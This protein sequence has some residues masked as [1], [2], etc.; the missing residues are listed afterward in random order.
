MSGH[1]F[2]RGDT[3]T[4]SCPICLSLRRLGQILTDPS[5]SVSFVNEGLL[6]LQL[7]VIRTQDK[8]ELDLLNQREGEGGAAPPVPPTNRGVSREEEPEGVTGENRPRKERKRRRD[9]SSPQRPKAKE[10]ASS[11]K[12]ISREDRSAS[13]KEEEGKPKKDKAHKKDKKSRSRDRTKRDKKNPKEKSASKEESPEKRRALKAAPLVA[14]KKESSEEEVTEEEEKEE[15]RKSPRL[16]SI[17]PPR[18][19]ANPATLGLETLPPRPSREAETGTPA[20]SGREERR[21]EERDEDRRERGREESS[22]RPRQ[23]RENSYHHPSPHQW[24]SAPRYTPKGAKKREK[25]AEIRRAGGVANWYASKK[26]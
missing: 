16:P 17:T 8:G 22:R 11:S 23:W 4:C 26:G 5:H 2:S 15:E 13:R 7:L 20:G 25:Q 10:S 14:V 6:E 1:S 12:R 24:G 3:P 19:T 9:S 18:E 21:R